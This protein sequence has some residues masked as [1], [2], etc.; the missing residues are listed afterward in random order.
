VPEVGDV[1]CSRHYL[2]LQ[3]FQLVGSPRELFVDVKGP[4]QLGASLPPLSCPISRFNTSQLGVFISAGIMASAPYTH[5]FSSL[6]RR[7]LI[8]MRMTLLADSAWLL[9]CG[10]STDMNVF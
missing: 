1:P 4:S 5:Y 7:F 9:A 3:R 6:S 8:P 2:A 10:C